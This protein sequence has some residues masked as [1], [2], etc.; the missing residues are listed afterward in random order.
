MS[1]KQINAT[2]YMESKIVYKRN[3]GNVVI[4]NPDGCLFAHGKYST[5]IL[6]SDLPEWYIYGY[7]YK[8][9]GYMSAKGVKHLLYVPNYV[10]YNHLHKYDTLY[11]SYNAEIEPYETEYGSIWYKGYDHA[12]G[13]SLIAEFVEA[14]GKYSDYDVTNIQKEIAR[15][16]E[17]YYDKNPEEAKANFKS[18]LSEKFGSRLPYRGRDYLIGGVGE[19]KSFFDNAFCVPVTYSSEQ[20]KTACIKIYRELAQRDLIVKVQ[21][22]AAQMGVKPTGLKINNAKNCLS[23]CTENGLNFSWRLIMADD[24]VIDYVVVYELAHILEYKHSPKF[25]KIIEDI[26]PDYKNRQAKLKECKNK[27]IK[28]LLE[29]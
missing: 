4:S 24:D 8:R 15:K 14:A 11:I 3:E 21:K 6:P 12:I 20:I 18:P 16:R 5:K 10:F 26:L 22:Y 17:F 9:H 29:D 28:E 23:S 19:K 7:M 25:W 2:L 27:L 13:S 1:K